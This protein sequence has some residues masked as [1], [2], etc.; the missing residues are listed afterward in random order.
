MPPVTHALG[1][2]AALAALGIV[3]SSSAANAQYEK[4][5]ELMR[6]DVKTQ[7]VAIITEAMGL[8]DEQS[9]TFGR[10]TG[11]TTWSYRSSSIGESP[12]SSRSL[13]ATRR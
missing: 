2:A 7:K 6:E 12:S 1:K 11:N 4:Y 5:V 3:L 10:S 13:P 8:T 9:S